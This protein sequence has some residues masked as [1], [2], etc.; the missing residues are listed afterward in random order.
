MQLLSIDILST[1][2]NR[3]KGS[4]PEASVLFYGLQKQE[5]YKQISRV[6]RGG[7]ILSVAT[8]QGEPAGR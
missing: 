4:P 8:T 7:I 3:Q 2:E 6:P 5:R 1:R